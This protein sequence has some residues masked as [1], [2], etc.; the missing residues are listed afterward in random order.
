MHVYTQTKIPKNETKKTV[1]ASIKYYFGSDFCCV[2][3][4]FSVFVCWRNILN[5]K[6]QQKQ[7]QR[8]GE[9]IP[10]NNKLSSI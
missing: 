3:V 6:I 4:E 2:D 7:Q 9:R 5:I 10:K 8:R 1:Y